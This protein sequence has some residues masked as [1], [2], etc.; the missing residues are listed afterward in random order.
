MAGL[1]KKTYLFKVM[2]L[3]W[4]ARAYFLET[5]IGRGAEEKRDGSSSLPELD[6]F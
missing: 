6:L 1:F 3:L 4:K 2:V 5:A